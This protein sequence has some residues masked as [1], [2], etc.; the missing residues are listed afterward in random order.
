MYVLQQC[1]RLGYGTSCKMLS[2]LFFH[3]IFY[4]WAGW[5]TAAGLGYDGVSI[6]EASSI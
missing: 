5:T 3:F 1:Y 6:V 2:N 4:M